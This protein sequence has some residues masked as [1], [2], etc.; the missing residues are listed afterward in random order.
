MQVQTQIRK[1][2]DLL[3]IGLK[4]GGLVVPQLELHPELWPA[5]VK[6]P[7]ECKRHVTSLECDSLKLCRSFLTCL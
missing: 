1:S 4:L 5:L 7:V 3:Y 6:I 2:L